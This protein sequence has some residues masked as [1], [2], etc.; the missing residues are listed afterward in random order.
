MAKRDLQRLGQAIILDPFD[1]K[2]IQKILDLTDL[3]TVLLGMLFSMNNIMERVMAP[4]RIFSSIFCI[5]SA[6]LLGLTLFY[7]PGC[8]AEKSGT[9]TGSWVA[10]GTRDM[11]PFAENRQVALFRLAGHVNLNDTVGVDSD[12][13]SEC[14]GLA[15]SETGSDIRCTWSSLDGYKIFLVL[16]AQKLAL[17][18]RV[19][20]TIIGGTGAAT[21][22][23]GSL[24]FTWSSMSFQRVDKNNAIGGYAK[25][26][27]GSYKLP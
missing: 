26:L 4:K 6:F 17:G 15:D 13:W 21:G 23:S 7:V 27:K 2:H 8:Y 11:L 9:F 5:T 24:E 22:I 16:K 20:G 19:S 25:A 12:Y 14:I 18:S 10:N 1:K 3:I